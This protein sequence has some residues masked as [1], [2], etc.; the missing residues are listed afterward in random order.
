MENNLV[1]IEIL[2]QLHRLVQNF[3]Q[4]SWFLHDEA[5][6]SKHFKEPHQAKS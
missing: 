4:T 3:I 5:S 6:R 1:Q 2:Y